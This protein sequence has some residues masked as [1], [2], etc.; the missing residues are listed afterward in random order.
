ML[1]YK[2]KA[3]FVLPYVSLVIE[4]EKYIKKLLNRYNRNKPINERIKVRGFYGDHAGSRSFK[5][6]I[7]ICTIEKANGIFNTLL[8]RNRGN[9]IGCLVFDEFHVLGNS[10][11]G[12]LI[13]ILIRLVYLYYIL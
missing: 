10:F 5:E 4:K 8:M 2:K 6:H 7:L 9:Q 11:N 12:A 13:E 1:L 3:I